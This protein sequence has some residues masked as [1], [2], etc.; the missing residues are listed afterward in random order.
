MK[1]IQFSQFIVHFH[2]KFFQVYLTKYHMLD[3]SIMWFLKI[4]IVSYEV[5]MGHFL[6]IYLRKFINHN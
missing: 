6:K 4:K 1:I 2:F 3:F 5:I